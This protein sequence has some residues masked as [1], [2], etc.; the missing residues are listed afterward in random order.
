[1]I[2]LDHFKAFNDN[3]GHLAGD[4]ALRTFASVSMA[5][6]RKTDTMARIGGEEFALLL[7]GADLEAT[8]AIAE[9]LRAAIESSSVEID[10]VRT[11]RITASFGVANSQTHGTDRL[12]LRRS[13][14]RALY[15]AKQQGSNRVIAA[16]A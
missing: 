8:L 16:D 2:D 13:A 4:E 10:A 5:T 14:D 1:V 7:R 3:Y 15:S 12:R 9:K 11:A 6:L